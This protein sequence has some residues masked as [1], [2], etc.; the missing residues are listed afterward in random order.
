MATTSGFPSFPNIQEDC[1]TN[2]RSG[3]KFT[4]SIKIDG[5]NIKIRVELKNGH[6]KL[7]E[8]SRRHGSSL[9]DGTDY[10]IDQIP[11]LGLYGKALNLNKIIRTMFVFAVRVAVSL[12]T[13]SVSIYG[14]VFKSVEQ[15]FTSF[16]PFAYIINDNIIMMTKNVYD[17]FFSCAITMDPESGFVTK[18]KNVFTDSTQM[19]EFLNTS[20]QLCVFPPPVVFSGGNLTECINTLTPSM[21][22]EKTIFEGYFIVSNTGGFK[23]KRLKHE[24]QKTIIF[25]NGDN[26]TEEESKTIQLLQ[27]VYDDRHRSTNPKKRIV[28][29]NKNNNNNSKKLSEELSDATDTVF[30]KIS[31][32]SNLDDIKVFA[33]TIRPVVIEELLDRYKNTT[34]PWSEK[35]IS[36][37]IIGV[38]IRQYKKL[39]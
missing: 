7:E 22:D 5:S 35:E 32:P 8:L 10:T 16:H 12:N 28:G 4:A 24:Q 2:I 19:T 6:W 39:M 18:F 34:I 25:R 21:M 13:T 29:E 33:L 31:V 9:I 38:I 26:L 1:I 20:D 37:I 3:Q 14:E 23:W 17:I 30:S 11:V 15:S 27:T 36:K